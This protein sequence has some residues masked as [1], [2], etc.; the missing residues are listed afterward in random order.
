LLNI[1]FISALIQL[2]KNRSDLAN[3]YFVQGTVAPFVIDAP[4]GE[5]DNEYRGAVAKFLPESTE[6]LVV[7]LSSSHWGPIVEGGLRDSTGKEYILVS[8]SKIHADAG[9]TVDEI[10]IDG[11]SH[12]CSRYGQ[13]ENRTVIESV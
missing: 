3:E 10:L 11:N 5:L 13:A 1:S 7:L 2:A 12:R 8:E 4:F 6:Q 9:K